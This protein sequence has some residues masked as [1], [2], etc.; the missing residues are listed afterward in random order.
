L[1]VVMA[2][3]GAAPWPNAAISPAEHLREVFYRQGFNDQ[4]CPGF[5][6][7]GGGRAKQSL[8]P[9]ALQGIVGVGFGLHNMRQQLLPMV[10]EIVAL[11]GAHTL[12][13]AYPQRSGLGEHPACRVSMCHSGHALHVDH[14]LLPVAFC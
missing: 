5:V 3:A 11:S 8:R 10:Q 1:L 7:S 2:A 6:Q 9:H 4:V 13:R 14:A 12:G